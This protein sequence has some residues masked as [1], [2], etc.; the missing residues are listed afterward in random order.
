LLRKRIITA[1]VLAPAVVA[2][3][4]FLPTLAVAIVLGIFWLVG[5]WEWAGFAQINN[6][7][8]LVYLVPFLMVMIAALL[9]PI[10]LGFINWMFIGTLLWW[11]IALV[12]VF[13]YPMPITMFVTALSGFFVLLP[14]WLF[15]VYLH[16]TGGRGL[17]L[18]VLIIVW[19]ADVGGYIFGRTIG[20]LKMLPA[21]SPNKTWEG[22]IGGLVLAAIA[23]WCLSLVLALPSTVFIAVAVG[24]AVVSL[25]GDLTVS[26]FKRNLGLKNS[27]DLLPGHGGVLD[28]VDSLSA[29]VPAFVFCLNLV[30][31]GE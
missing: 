22:F 7:A 28:R 2:I 6:L 18:G 20:N 1:L 12:G 15:F 31:I 30:G 25:I 8:R 23:G 16:S 21:V 14:A 9:W 11:L 3:V 29:A 4:L 26:V 10:H 19:A 27:S 5:A 24:T 13:S 17:A